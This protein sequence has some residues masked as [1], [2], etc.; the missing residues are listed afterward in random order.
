MGLPPGFSVNGKDV[1]SPI[2]ETLN[3]S[4]S[5]SD[6]KSHTPNGYS[7]T[8]PNESS[9]TMEPTETMDRAIKEYQS[10]GN[11]GMYL[12]KYDANCGNGLCRTD[13]EDEGRIEKGKIK[14][15][16]YEELKEEFKEEGECS[17]CITLS[18]ENLNIPMHMI[19]L[20][21]PDGGVYYKYSSSPYHDPC[22]VIHNSTNTFMEEM[23]LESHY[24]RDS[25]ISLFNIEQITRQF[26]KDYQMG[27][28]KR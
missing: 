8:T 10:N 9:E 20:D 1:L 11:G 3:G 6:G 7:T 13:I 17:G 14:V 18:H 15:R 21:V 23:Q 22:Y 27:N 26:I 28:L 16:G 4:S 19:I 24:A 2:W 25:A 5:F 12:G